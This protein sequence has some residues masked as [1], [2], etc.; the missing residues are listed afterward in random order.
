[1]NLYS[2]SRRE[3]MDG[4]QKQKN[5]NISG[6][7]RNG[8]RSRNRKLTQKILSEKTEYEHGKRISTITI[9]NTISLSDD[10]EKLAIYQVK[11]AALLRQDNTENIESDIATLR[12]AIE[13]QQSYIDAY[14]KE[15]G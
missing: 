12:A 11:L 1:M 14:P 7:T 8:R 6:S 4:L 3:H 5:W 15:A 2:E 9:Q 10:L 13:I